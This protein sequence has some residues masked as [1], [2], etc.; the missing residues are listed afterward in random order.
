MARDPF[1]PWAEPVPEIPFPMTAAELAAMPDDAHGYELVDGRLV[2]M[3]PTGGLHGYS[4]LGLSA[5]LRV[6]VDEHALGAA[7][8][9]ETGFLVSRPEEPD[10]VLAL[11][12]AFVRAER[13]PPS[14]DPAWLGFLR[15]APDLVIEVVSP[16]QYGPEMA[17]KAKRWLVAG[18]RL[19]W[20]VWP[21]TK[22]V[23]VLLPAGEAPAEALGTGETLGGRDVVP[24]FSYALSRLFR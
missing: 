15:L 8:G 3:A 13:L 23:D 9:A 4:T 24:G 18:A 10:T 5:A 22:R 14:G 17:E 11:D 6:Y 21:A 19:V 7:F 1:V 16:S 12:A 20:I 2:K